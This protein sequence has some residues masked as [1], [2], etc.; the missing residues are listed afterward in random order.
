MAMKLYAVVI[1]KAGSKKRHVAENPFAKYYE[2][3]EDRR[4]YPLAV[5]ELR[6]EADEVKAE[7]VKTTGRKDIF[8]ISFWSA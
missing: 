5:F 7:I 6:S 8:I 3:A 4:Y 1:G 2:G